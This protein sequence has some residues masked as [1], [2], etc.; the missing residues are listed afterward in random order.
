MRSDD[1]L[2]PRLLADFF[3]EGVT[4]LSGCGFDADSLDPIRS[5]LALANVNGQPLLLTK[6]AHER[7][8][9]SGRVAPQAMIDMSNRQTEA[10][11]DEREHGEERRGGIDAT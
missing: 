4:T 1:P 9:R 10:L 7:L 6:Q 8:V 11:L 2:C 5:E 3:E